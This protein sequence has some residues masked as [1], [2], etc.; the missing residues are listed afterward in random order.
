MADKISKRI[1][2]LKPMGAGDADCV[3]CLRLNPD[4]SIEICKRCIA[5][6]PA[7]HE[8]MV[9]LSAAANSIK[10]GRA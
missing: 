10:A 5:D 1:E 3:D 4:V 8:A 9:R 6:A 2:L 7:F